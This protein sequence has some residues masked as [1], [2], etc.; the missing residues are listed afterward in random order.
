MVSFV[1]QVC[2]L[3]YILDR[4][5]ILDKNTRYIKL[6]YGKFSGQ[7]EFKNI[8]FILIEVYVIILVYL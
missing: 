7:L 8:L 3:N 5:E 2:L 1:S 6:Y 4:V